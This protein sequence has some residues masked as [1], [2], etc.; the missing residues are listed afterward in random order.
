MSVMRD[1]EIFEP[2]IVWSI[3]S[4]GQLRM[5]VDLLADLRAFLKS[6]ESI[7]L[8]LNIPEDESPLREFSDLPITIIRNA[9]SEGFGANHN[10]AFEVSP[11][12]YFIVI[13][14]DVRLRRLSMSL[15]LEPFVAADVAAVAPLILSPDGKVEDSVRR[16]P[17]FGRLFV[18]SVL[19]RRKP[20][21]A[22]G[23]MPIDV[24]W[25]AGMFVMFRSSAFRR[26]AGFD[27]RYFMYMEDADICRRLGKSGFRTIL[28]PHTYV[29]HDAQ[30]A[31]RRNFQHLRW[32]LSSAFRFLL[33]PI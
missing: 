16:F 15:L 26:V 18:R 32:H 4:H 24:D 2:S 7:I 29:V 31:S 6:T 21:Y 23:N 10:K 28:Q 1:D 14:P 25:S 17:T 13:N 3:V 11:S 30:R 27:T 8:V 20:D 5:I 22:A 33:L 9:Q 19:R 12:L